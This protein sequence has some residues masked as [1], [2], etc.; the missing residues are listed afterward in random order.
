MRYLL[1]ALAA[2]CAPA[3]STLP[4]PSTT[5]AQSAP[6]AP[7]P[8]TA[9]STPAAPAAPRHTSPEGPARAYIDA[10]DRCT[11]TPLR[12]A[13]HPASHLVR[14]DDAGAVQSKTM[15]AWWLAIDAP[16]PCVPA[17]ERTLTVLDREGPMAIVASYARYATHR[18]HDLL[19][20]VDT[21]DGWR[22]VDKVYDML[23]PEEA[24]PPWSDEPGVR[25]ALEQKIRAALD[26]DPALLA[27]SHLDECIYSA[28]HVAGVPYARASVSEWAARYA[29][30]RER[31][32][33][34]RQAQWRV[35]ASKA[36]GKIAFAKLDVVAHGRRYVDHIALLR[37][38]DTWRIAAAVWGDPS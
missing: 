32:E 28:V 23:K 26:N 36:S 30:R 18:F 1:L 20:V 2:S 27:S 31:G 12:T 3:A 5:T 15:L 29:A 11:S 34:G 37:V 14:V 16:K 17:L 7:S 19:L 25:S 33:D 13:F 8:T 6:A 35:L 9:R 22:V 4:A 38:K 10:S 24:P 21:P